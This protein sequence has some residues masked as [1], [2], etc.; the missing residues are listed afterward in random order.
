[1]SLGTLHSQNQLHC[2]LAGMM[3][4]PAWLWNTREP[5]LSFRT[6][7]STAGFYVANEWHSWVPW[8]YVL[9]KECTPCLLFS[10][11]LAPSQIQLKVW[12][13][14]AGD[15]CHCGPVRRFRCPQVGHRRCI[16]PDAAAGGR[17]MRFSVTGTNPELNR[18]SPPCL[19]SLPRQCS[20]LLL[21]LLPGNVLSSPCTARCHCHFTSELSVMG[22]KKHQCMQVWEE[23][24]TASQ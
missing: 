11:P 17:E 10:I 22:L 7:L 21:I 6:A 24:P 3:K 2:T 13:S 5:S 16:M 19:F 23:N 20:T 8:P 12:C 14:P 18:P 1:M 4:H 15:R 9:W